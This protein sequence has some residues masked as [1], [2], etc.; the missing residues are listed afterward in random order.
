M[1]IVCEHSRLGGAKIV[2]VRHT[3]HKKMSTGVSYGEQLV[4]DIERLQRHFPAV[5]ANVVLIDVEVPHH[6]A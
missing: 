2:T 6:S 4:F 1:K 5:P 3:L